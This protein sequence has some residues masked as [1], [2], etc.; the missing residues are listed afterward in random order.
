MPRLLRRAAART[1]LDPNSRTHVGA[2][3]EP[4]YRSCSA[5]AEADANVLNPVISNAVR[6]TLER[7]QVTL[8]PSK[9]TFVAQERLNGAKMSLNV[10]TPYFVSETLS[11]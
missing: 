10:H 5:T 1:S 4:R 9:R 8:R 3:V 7:L 2:R 6:L 11:T